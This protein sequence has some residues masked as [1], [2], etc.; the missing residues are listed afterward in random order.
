MIVSSTTIGVVGLGYVGLPLAILVKKKGYRVHGVV[1]TKRRASLINK[2]IC[3]FEDRQLASDLKKYPI[4]TS[5]S[6]RSLRDCEI[7]VVCV[8]TPVKE[9]YMPDYEPLVSSTQRIGK[10]LKKGHLVIFESTVNPGAIKEVIIPLLENISH[11][12]V[13]DDFDISHC[14]E[15]INPG[16][17]K[18]S[19]QNIPRVI[20]SYTEKGLIRT[21]DFY[22]SILNAKVKLMKSIEE[23]EAV[24]IVENCFRDVNIAFVN[25]LAMSFNSLGL[26]I[27]NILDGASTKPFGF[28]RHNPSCG[29]GGHCIPV[30][31]YYMIE[32]AKKNGFNHRLLSLARK[33]NNNMPLYVVS[34]VKKSIIKNRLPKNKVKIA[35]LGLAYKANIDD[36]RESPAFLIINALKKIGIKPNIFD[37]HVPERS[38]VSSLTQALKGADAIIIATD[39]SEFVKKLTPTL[40]KKFGISIVIDGRN[41]LDK[42]SFIESGID[43]H[44][45]GR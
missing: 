5:T 44:G 2:R 36:C 13:G 11:L 1:K 24:K 16:D 18:W 26:D 22:H 39:H 19:I 23:A 28:M 29:V 10:I 17:K 21:Y 20:G 7:I 8:P 34:K 45:I 25:E 31:P 4:V 15:R 32:H 42:E 37:P 40:V 41:C 3:P 9:N 33:I 14:P 12:K 6:F 30:D 27:K 35:L 43:Y 38:N